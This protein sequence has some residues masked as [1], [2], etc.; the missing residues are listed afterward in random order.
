MRYPTIEIIPQKFWGGNSYV[1]SMGV[2]TSTMY[3]KGC[4]LHKNHGCVDKVLHMGFKATY[5]KG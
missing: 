4:L 3:G 5:S 1:K 2:G